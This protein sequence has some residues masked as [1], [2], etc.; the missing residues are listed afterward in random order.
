MPTHT[1]TH[2]DIHSHTHR[3]TQTH[4]DTHGAGRYM[5]LEFSVKITEFIDFQNIKNVK[6]TF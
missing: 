3:H 4:T 6:Q 1:K 5:N 2:K